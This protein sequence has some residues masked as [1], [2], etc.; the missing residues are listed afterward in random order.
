MFFL[1]LVGFEN[2][3]HRILN[4]SQKKTFQWKDTDAIG[5]YVFQVA[6][7]NKFEDILFEEELDQKTYTYTIDK[8]FRASDI[9]L[10]WRV[11]YKSK[12]TGREVQKKSTFDIN[13]GGKLAPLKDTFGFFYTVSQGRFTQTGSDQGQLEEFQN[14]P[15]TLGLFYTYR[16]NYYDSYAMSIYDSQFTP[17]NVT[18]TSTTLD[19]PNE[20]GLNFYRQHR[21]NK[22]WEYYYGWDYEE[23]ST[24]NLDE[25]AAS[26]E[27]AGLKRQKLHFLTMGLS[28][29]FRAFDRNFLFKG[30]ASVIVD[31]SDSEENRVTGRTFSGYK[32]ILYFNTRLYKSVSAQVLLK[33]HHLDDGSLANILR[34]GAGIGIAF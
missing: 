32:G 22:S 17:V 4:K 27:S 29:V 14:S 16:M 25:L 26:L 8:A 23:F 11:K 15:L 21:F 31:S 1:L 3:M 24:F 20:R 30:S 7:T 12:K 13:N 18:A 19:L 2:Q 6:Y 33:Y 10:N 28:H 5:K 9:T 34:Y